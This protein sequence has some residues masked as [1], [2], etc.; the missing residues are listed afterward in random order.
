MNRRR[1]SQSA[2]RADSRVVLGVAALTAIWRQVKYS[3]P[4]IAL[5]SRPQATDAV[6]PVPRAPV[7]TKLRPGAA[8]RNTDR[9]SKSR[10]SAAVT[11]GSTEMRK[12]IVGLAVVLV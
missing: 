9:G 11:G 12:V 1:Q 7:S 2:K 5:D 8:S 4:Q 10:A 6:H 3:R